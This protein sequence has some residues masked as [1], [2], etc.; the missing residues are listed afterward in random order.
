VANALTNQHSNGTLQILDSQSPPQPA[1]VQGV[2]AWATSDAT[3]L[4][5]APAADGMSFV[6]TTVAVGTARL[7]VTADADLGTGVST[8]TGVSEDVVVTQNPNTVA[9]TF[10]ITFGTF[11]DV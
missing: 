1:P 3:V 9:S 7:T 8:I 6:A 11:T 5:V 4:T 10:V 2:P